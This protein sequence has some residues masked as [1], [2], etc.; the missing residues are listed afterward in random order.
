MRSEV[1]KQGE[2]QPIF[3]IRIR[4]TRIILPA[5][6]MILWIRLEKPTKIMGMFYHPGNLNIFEHLCFI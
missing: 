4:R 2:L 3:R 5:P 6:D 1:N